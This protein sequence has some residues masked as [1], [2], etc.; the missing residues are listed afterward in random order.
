[1]I[2]RPAC[3]ASAIDL[4]RPSGASETRRL[5]ELK[6]RNLRAPLLFQKGFELPVDIPPV[7]DG[8]HDNDKFKISDPV[9]NSIVRGAQGSEPGQLVREWLT[10]Q[11]IGFERF[12]GF[13]QDRFQGRIKV[14]YTVFRL[15]GVFDG[16]GLQ[17]HRG[18]LSGKTSS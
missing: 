5:P 1:M 9:N 17:W 14:T 12:D 6:F 16:V 8:N 2:E 3:P 4:S 11:G 18:Y 15:F 13:L 7:A 10:S